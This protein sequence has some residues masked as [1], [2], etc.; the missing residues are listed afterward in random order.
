MQIT[1]DTRKM[2]VLFS[3]QPRVKEIRM[4]FR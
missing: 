4:D 3:L 1:F 2:F